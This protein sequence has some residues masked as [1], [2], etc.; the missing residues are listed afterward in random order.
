MIKKL[1][2]TVAVVAALT[3]LNPDSAEAKRKKKEVEYQTPWCIEN[4]GVSEYVLPDKTRVDCLT[5]NY[6]VEFDFAN[7]WAEAVG[8]AL[9]YS[10][11]TGKKPAVVLIFENRDDIKHWK[12]IQKISESLSLYNANAVGSDKAMKLEVRTVINW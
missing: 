9:H 10:L 1:L 2:V 6:A 8:Q 11:M 7:K 4:G 3:A 12:K 5:D